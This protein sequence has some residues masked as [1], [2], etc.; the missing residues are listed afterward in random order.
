MNIYIC[1][2]L[3]TTQSQRQLF[4]SFT[5]L[6]VIWSTTR[7]DQAGSCSQHITLWC[8]KCACDVLRAAASL[9]KWF[10]LSSLQFESFSFPDP[11]EDLKRELPSYLAKVDDV[12]SEV[13][14][15]EWWEEIRKSTPSL[16]CCLQTD[17]VSPALLCSSRAHFSLLTNHFS[18]QQTSARTILKL[19]LCFNTIVS[20]LLIVNF[21]PWSR[22]LCWISGIIGR[23]QSIM[24]SVHEN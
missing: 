21:Q 10:T 3:V 4:A 23:I 20:N 15:L 19:P 7:C 17:I 1:G 9:L 22:I 16:V 18:E 12:S 6:T 5:K 13:A 8:A 11:I 2:H 14:K 24:G